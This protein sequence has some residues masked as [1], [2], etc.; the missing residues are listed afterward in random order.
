M[1]SQLV[2]ERV[3][4]CIGEEWGVLSRV[5]ARCR[6]EINRSL[7]AARRAQFWRSAI[8]EALLALLRQGDDSGAEAALRV[9]AA[10]HRPG[11]AP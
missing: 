11:T 9:R 4:G 7:P 10:D 6:A 2:R 5:V 8:D 3:A 1:V